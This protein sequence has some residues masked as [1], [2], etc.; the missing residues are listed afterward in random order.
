MDTKPEYGLPHFLTYIKSIG[1]WNIENL[2]FKDPIDYS[3]LARAVLADILEVTMYELINNVELDFDLLDLTNLAP[4][5]NQSDV[6]I[7][8]HDASIRGLWIL[9]EITGKI[10]IKNNRVILQSAMFTTNLVWEEY[11]DPSDLEQLRRTGSI[12]YYGRLHS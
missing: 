1:G 9:D 3:V 2:V 8:L 11:L 4:V 12:R 5:I 10:R 7:S 6:L